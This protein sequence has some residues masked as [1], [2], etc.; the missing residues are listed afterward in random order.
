MEKNAFKFQPRVERS[1]VVGEIS[2]LQKQN[3]NSRPSKGGR[4][5]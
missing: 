4:R 2:K 5:S 3:S 1:R